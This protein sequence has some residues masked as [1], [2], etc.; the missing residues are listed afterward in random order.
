M[1]GSVVA[2]DAIRHRQR[3]GRVDSP[4]ETTESSKRR[5]PESHRATV[6]GRVSRNDNI[7]QG[8]RSAGLPNAAAGWRNVFSD[9]VGC[10][11]VSNRYAGNIDGAARL[12]DAVIAAGVSADCQ[13]IRAWTSDGDIGRKDGKSAREIDSADDREINSVVTEETIRLF[14]GS[15]QRALA[16]G[17]CTGPIAG[18]DVGRVADGID[19][20]YDRG[21]SWRRLVDHRDDKKRYQEYHDCASV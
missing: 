10:S 9:G 8:E 18:C 12:K 20:E 13:K 21:V 14:D 11:S 5:A 1:S 3:A 6:A 4:S 19:C 7:A 2:D 15:A 16:V 17:V